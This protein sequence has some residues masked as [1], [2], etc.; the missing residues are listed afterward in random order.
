MTSKKKKIKL[1]YV[2][3]LVLSLVVPSQVLADEHETVQWINHLEFL[4]G[5]S[6]VA[7]SYTPINGGLKV[8]ASETGE[9]FIVQGLP[10]APGFLVTG[11]RVCYELTDPESFISQIAITQLEDPPVSRVL[12]LNDT[13][14]LSDMGPICV[15]STPSFGDIDPS[16][17]A[18]NLSLG[19][20]FPDIN[21][22]I[23]VLGV[24][25]VMVPDPDSPMA[26]ALQE[27]QDGLDEVNGRVDQVIVDLEDVKVDL[28]DV[29][30]DLEDVKIELEDVKNDL[31]NHTHT[32]LTGKG[33]GHNN[34]VATSGSVDSP[35]VL[36]SNGNNNNTVATSG[37][38]DSPLVLKSNGNNNSSSN[39]S[40][41]GNVFNKFSRWI[42]WR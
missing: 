24:G 32:Y 13:T 7:T 6:Y 20:W 10:V 14:E 5:V 23:T 16:Q 39:S 27:L 8:T 42:L 37:S 28:E 3:L 40:K 35:L 12:V 9:N 4:P 21:D 15:N 22:S 26:Q 30:D 34:T 33:T 18:L 38:V 29:K 36:K 17:G 25:L 1:I 11:I 19:M 31:V 2:V 41:K